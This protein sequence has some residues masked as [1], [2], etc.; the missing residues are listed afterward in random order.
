MDA[1]AMEQQK[2]SA[3]LTVDTTLSARQFYQHDPLLVLLKEKLHLNNFCISAGA[4]FLPGIVYPVW[5]LLSKI[6]TH[7]HLSG[8]HLNDWFSIIIQFFFLFPCLFLIYTF[9]PH[10][11]AKLF[12]ALYTGGVIGNY[13]KDRSGIETYVHFEQKMIRWIDNSWWAV[14]TIVLV[15]FYISLRLFWLEET[16]TGHHTNP[17]SFMPFVIQAIAILIYVPLMFATGMNVIRLVLALVFINRLFYLFKLQV[18]PIHADGAGGLGSVENLL[19][20]CV[21]MMLWLAVL[22]AAAILGPELTTLSYSEMFLLAAIYIVLIPTL[23]IG[24]LVFP[25]RMMVDA[26]NEALQSLTAEY[27]HALTQSLSSGAQDT[28]GISAETLRLEALKKRYDLVYSSFPVWPLDT[29]AL[30][31]IGVTVIIPIILPIILPAILPSIISFISFAFQ[32]TGH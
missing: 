20:L 3:P 24:C 23:I 22:L 17:Q 4:M 19:W 28:P 16:L 10:T 27:Q 13:R 15:M 5:W 32:G 6:T 26:R 31:R 11:I 1:D 30:S 29:S 2:N 9:I 7:S 12:N 25:H 14:A 18:K 8:W 21:S